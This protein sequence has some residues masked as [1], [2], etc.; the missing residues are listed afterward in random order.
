MN[1]LDNLFGSSEGYVRQYGD[2]EYYEYPRNNSS[3]AST[4]QGPNIFD[5]PYGRNS[6]YDGGSS[7]TH[8]NTGYPSHDG[9]S[10]YTH[11]NT[12]YPSYDSAGSSYS[13]YNE[14]QTAKNAPVATSD[15]ETEDD[16]ESEVEELSKA[17]QETLS[18]QYPAPYGMPSIAPFQSIMA[19]APRSAGM[20]TCAG[21]HRTLGF[22]RFL[23]CL[24]QNWHPSCFK[25]RHCNV[26]ISDREFSVQGSAPYH[27]NCYKEVFHPKCEIC[28][29]YIPA[30]A[31]GLIEY[32][33]HPYWNQKYCPSHEKDGAKRCCSC[34]RIE[35][36]GIQYEKL[37]DGRRLCSECQESAV[38]DTKGCQ[39]LFREILKFYKHLG[40]PITQ[41]IPMLL[42]ERS[43]LNSALYVEK[44]GHIHTS[45]TRGLCLSEEQT[46]T[47]VSEK[48]G[49]YFETESKK[50]IRHCEVTAIL[51][52]YGLP[53]LLT[54]SI[55]AHELMHAWLRLKGTFPSLDNS[56]EEGICQVMS[57]IWLREELDKM[58]KKGWSSSS[59]SSSTSAR[60]GEFFLHQ[61]ETDAS[62]VYGDGFRAGNAA[63]STFG[64]ARTL[65]HLRMTGQ[66]P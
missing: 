11:Q 56:I 1:W 18:L 17:M 41:E 35:P 12:G 50:L 47:T 65:E 44:D 10:S 30:N 5:D 3:S 43:A 61:I 7:Y 36:A 29:E 39:S 32:R 25:C 24:G 28:H 13:G 8:P 37:E 54:G 15:A 14:R 63:A 16:E 58:R 34:D 52:L 22:G 6:S 19:P 64:L 49:G 62:P 59:S 26:P 21:C 57:Y 48:G 55:L 31:Q 46:I 27:R 33:S 23:T 2:G 45:E 60:L 51:V 53:R 9:G 66:F 40:M 20:S 42:V 4:W 38:M